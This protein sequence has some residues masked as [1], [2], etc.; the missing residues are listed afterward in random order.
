MIWGDSVIHRQIIVVFHRDPVK[1]RRVAWWRYSGAS[2]LND[3]EVASSIP[4]RPGSGCATTLGKLFTPMCLD[5]YCL[6]YDIKSSSG[7]VLGTGKEAAS[8]AASSRPSVCEQRGKGHALSSPPRDTG[9]PSVADRL[10]YA[11]L[12]RSIS[13]TSICR[14]LSR[15][16]VYNKSAT[17]PRRIEVTESRALG[18]VKLSYLT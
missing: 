10:R 15:L 12:L 8:A 7:W 1:K 6:R 17:N 18:D 11:S 3:R 14:G 4:A 9:E 5:V 2:N 16:V 13:S